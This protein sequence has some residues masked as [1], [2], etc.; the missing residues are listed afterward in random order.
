MVCIVLHY[1][2]FPNARGAHTP[3]VKEFKAY[4]NEADIRCAVRV[5]G[6]I[7]EWLKVMTRVKQGCVLSPLIFLMVMDWILRRNTIATTAGI[8]WMR[9]KNSVTSQML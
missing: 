3:Y 9:T 5:E 7:G 8:Q 2:T 4:T 6:K 1:G